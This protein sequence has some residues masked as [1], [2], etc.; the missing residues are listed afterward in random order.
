MASLVYLLTYIGKSLS[1]FFSWLQQ[2][3]LIQSGR[4]EAEAAQLR[5]KANELETATRVREE[6]RRRNSAVPVTDSLPDDGFRR[7]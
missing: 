6:V 1:T 5:E 4:V 3:Q 2:N 7:D